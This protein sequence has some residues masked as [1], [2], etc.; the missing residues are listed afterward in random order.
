MSG[1]NDE[2]PRSRGNMESA[3]RCYSKT[4]QRPFVVATE[5]EDP[6]E[7]PTRKFLVFHDF[8]HFKAWYH[9]QSNPHIHEI[10]RCA[11]EEEH[12]ACGRLIFDFDLDKPMEGCIDSFVPKEFEKV[13]QFVVGK[14]FANYYNDVDLSKLVPVWQETRYTHKFSMHLIVKNAFFSEYW[15]RQM[16]IFYQLMVR[17]ANVLGLGKYMDALDMQIPRKNATF[18]MIGSSKVGGKKIELKAGQ[19]M[20]FDD[21][22]VGVY[23]FDGLTKEQKLEMSNLN[24]AYIQQIIK[25]PSSGDKSKSFKDTLQR[26]ITMEKEGASLNVDDEDINSAADIFEQWDQTWFEM[27]DRVGNI[28]N[29][30]RIN[31]GPCPISGHHHSRE[32]AYLKLMP[33]GCLV[34]R[35]R[36]GCKKGKMYSVKLGMYKKHAPRPKIRDDSGTSFRRIPMHVS[37]ME[38][39]AD[40]KV[41]EVNMDKSKKS[42]P[43]RQLIVPEVRRIQI[44]RGLFT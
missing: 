38:A 26:C 21:C 16:K 10:I 9:K 25:E 3:Y 17:E 41:V 28:I 2:E 7:G 24:Y 14:T 4:R 35:C 36:R 30:N 13:I 1:V 6:G 15:P 43:N 33:D 8:N 42:G 11:E 5:I 29:L 23:D 34:F 44:P 32:N 19:D 40:A 22:L 39:M 37:R 12:R 27:R 31:A 18:R 20:T